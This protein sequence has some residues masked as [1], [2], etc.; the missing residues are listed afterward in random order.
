[1]ESRVRYFEQ[2]QACPD[3]GS[4]AA[5]P[6]SRPIQARIDRAALAGNL[7]EARRLANGARVMAIVKADGYGHGLV[8]AA[9]ALAEADGFGIASLEEALILRDAGIRQPLWLLEGF[10]ESRE[11]PDIARHGVVAVVH[12]ASQL[13]MLEN[14]RWK[15][16]LSVWVKIDTGMH[17]IGFSPEALPRVLERLADLPGVRCAGLMSHL[18]SADDPADPLTE[19]QR[20]VF[21]RASA[22]L[23]LARSLANSA[24]LVAWPGSRFDWVRPGIMLYG[25]APLADG[26]AG[27]AQLRPAM[28]LESRLIA[29]NRFHAGDA[30][31]YGA[32]WTCPEEMNVGVIA[33]G[34]GDGYP[35]H[36]PNGTPVLVEGVRVPIVGRVS[37]DMITVDLRAVPQ[38]RVGS[39]AVMW[40]PQLPVEEVARYAG[41]IAYEL[42]C[43]V[44]V[45]VPRLEI[46]DGA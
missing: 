26:T 3:R 35:R 14:G 37:M 11:L 38:A 33:C 32:S 43:E 16:A 9:R 42:L 6:M 46:T 4:L 12:H 18:A 8:R 23:E 15:D 22:G 25:A 20:A 10:F 30:I 5:R 1:M 7:E 36:A 28:T 17:R 44:A 41:T 34:Y 21:A 31:G 45:R 19:R 13:E 27:E 24:G 39:R 40:G 2:L 29:I